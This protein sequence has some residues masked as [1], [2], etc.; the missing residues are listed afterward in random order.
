MPV[1]L[2]CFFLALTAL[3]FV[4]APDASADG[5][6]PS[7][8]ARSAILVSVV[9]GKILFEK[10]AEERLPMA[11][12]T[13]IM[14]SL[15]ALENAPQGSEVTVPREAVGIEGTS[16]YLV[17]GERFSLLDL[18]YAVMLSS[19][20]D[21]ATAV[22]VH[23]GGTLENFVSMMNEKAASLGLSN[24]HFTNPHGLHDDDHYTT[25]RELAALAACALKNETFRTIVS[26]KKYICGSRVFVN[27]NKMLATYDGAIG[28]KTGFTKKSGRCLV[29]AAERD[30]TTLIAVTLSDPDD[31]RDHTALLDFGFSHYKT[32]KFAN[33]GDCFYIMPDMTGLRR[34]VRCVAAETVEKTVASGG[35]FYYLV[36]C[37]RYFWGEI[38]DGR[39][40]GSVK[41]TKNGS[42]VAEIP[43]VAEIIET[44]PKKSS[45][46][47]KIIDF[48]RKIFGNG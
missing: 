31:W 14:T 47:S 27:H 24:T 43:L 15:V 16:S 1:R 7:V 22:A 21:A 30:G 18:I 12:T 36:E 35:E 8:S 46:F 39:A 10:N 13:K 29:S 44:K 41:V 25:A 48:L 28:V 17:E 20:N 9:D 2:I 11:S 23:V 45:F 40:V 42:K 6:L 26:T 34:Q 19:A 37:P 3:L 4:A 5:I 33:A 38:E 32:I